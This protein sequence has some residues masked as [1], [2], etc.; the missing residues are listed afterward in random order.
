MFDCAKGICS[1]DFDGL[2]D[3]GLCNA[4]IEDSCAQK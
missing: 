3:L 2:Y 1:L 4:G